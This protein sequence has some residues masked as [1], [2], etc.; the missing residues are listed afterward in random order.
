MIRRKTIENISPLVTTNSI[1]HFYRATLCLS[2][3]FAVARCPSVRLSV[4]CSCILSTRQKISSN[5]FVRSGSPIILV[6]FD[7]RRRYPIPSWTPSAEAQ[8]TRGWENF[9][10][11]YRKRRLSRKRYE[12]DPCLLWKLI[13]SHMR[14]IEW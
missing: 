2:A 9:A 14:S 3:V 7:S 12:I 5:F 1:S 10:V 13:E 6:F 4:S 8:N 11:N